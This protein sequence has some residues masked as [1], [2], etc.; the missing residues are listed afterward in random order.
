MSV[1]V[2]SSS[3]SSDAGGG[4]S[5]AIIDAAQF[6]HR[7]RVVMASAFTGEPGEEAVC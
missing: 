3:P 4:E 2:T 7:R 5:G 6:V 1:N